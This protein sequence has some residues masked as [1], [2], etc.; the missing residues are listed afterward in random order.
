MASFLNKLRRATIMLVAGLF[1]LSSP[2]LACTGISLKGEDGTLVFARTLEWGTFDLQGEFIVIPRGMELNATPMPDGSAGMRWTAKYGVAG[3]TGM[4]KL[5][6]A[7]AVN[8]KGLTVG[9]FYLP[10]YTRYQ[11]YD[12]KRADI[13]IA[14]VDVP[15][16]LTSQFQTLDE[17]RAGLEKVRVVPV[18]EKII[19]I[20]PPVHYMVT[21][22]S[23]D[24][25][26]IQYI[27]GKMTV[28]EAPLGVVTNSPNYDWHILNLNN[29]LNLSAVGLSP[30]EA[31]GV[32]FAPLGAGSGMTGLPG[33]FT[34]PSR[35]VRAVAF[36][37]TA[38]K[39]EGGYDTVREAFRILDNFNVPAAAAEGSAGH[40]DGVGLVYSAT[41][42]TIATDIT[43]LRVY[44]H[45]QFSRN[46][47]MIDL[48]TIDFGDTAAG[49]RRI[50][51]DASREPAI[52]EVTAFSR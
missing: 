42:W 15:L 37:Q 39:T 32:K 16:Y 25:A 43:N 18:V 17:V 52:E 51:L 12:P 20:V 38:R 31:S 4:K 27:D 10:G 28:F 34:P 9:M 14:S 44:Y 41:Q 45:T 1:V 36:T 8:E 23:G 33:D 46:V 48:K 7:D 3:T 24:A 35:F 6:M 26:V 40:A 2:A 11:T 50:P 5:I 47:R 21:D 30:V 22:P 49:I 29:Y 19:G 13:S